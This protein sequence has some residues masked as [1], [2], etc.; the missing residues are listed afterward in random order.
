MV[1]PRGRDDSPLG[2]P[3]ITTPLLLGE[4]GLGVEVV[5]LADQDM[6]AELV[7]IAVTGGNPLN[8]VPNDDEWMDV[9]VVESEEVGLADVTPCT[10]LGFGAIIRTAL[11]LSNSMV[12]LLGNLSTSLVL[13][14]DV[15]PKTLLSF[16]A[17]LLTVER[18]GRKG[19]ITG[20]FGT[21]TFVAIG[22]S[23][24]TLL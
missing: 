8:T 20:S 21:H 19:D 17:S 13:A 2:C 12:T 9:G 23:L 7:E 18:A 14:N 10:T 6:L 16:L 11:P 5:V 1:A 15:T 22:N 4:V 3:L 24:A